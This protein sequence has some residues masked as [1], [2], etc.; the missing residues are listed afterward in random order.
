LSWRRKEKVVLSGARQ[1]AAK[2]DN[3][4][5]N[6]SMEGWM[7]KNK[8]VTKKCRKKGILDSEGSKR[9]SFGKE[10]LREGERIKKKVRLGSEREFEGV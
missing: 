10:K 7:V 6:Q 5:E 1:A 8:A 3:G 9:L 4:R 2:E